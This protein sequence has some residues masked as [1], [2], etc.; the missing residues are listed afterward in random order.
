MTL[1]DN[2]RLDYVNDSLSLIQ[3]TDAVTFGTDALLLAAYADRRGGRGL[4]LGAGTGIISLLLLSRGKID[5]AVAIEA[6]ADFAELTRRNA[7]LNGLADRLL[8]VN[9]D[10]RFYK[11]AD[12]YDIVYTNP[13]YMKAD[14]G[15]SCAADSKS[16]GRHELLGDIHDFCEAGK[17]LVR[18]GGSFLAV[19]RPER[20]A[21][22]LSAMREC[23]IE[24]KRL[25]LVHADSAS[26]PSIVLVEGRRGGKPGMLVTRPLFIYTDGSHTEYSPDMH[27][28]NGNGIFPDDFFVKNK[29]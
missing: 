7:E 6:Q 27:Y 9:S 14:S 19:Y 8:S 28:I 5:S 1:F 10:L 16:I 12:T 20:L 15:K 22:L 4:E 11:S 17:R 29:I 23:S 13:P 2:E 24:P 18:F 26:S 21:E 3:R 25:T